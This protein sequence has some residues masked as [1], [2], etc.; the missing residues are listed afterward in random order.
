MK[1]KINKENWK[2]NYVFTLSCDKI[3]IVKSIKCWKSK[4]PLYFLLPFILCLEL[5]LELFLYYFLCIL[6]FL[7]FTTLLAEHLFYFCFRVP[8]FIIFNFSILCHIWKYI[9]LD[10]YFFY[11]WNI[12]YNFIIEFMCTISEIYLILMW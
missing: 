5:F 9:T 7:L 1:I 2:S 8:L 4:L 10:F 3:D 11:W 12:V 6:E